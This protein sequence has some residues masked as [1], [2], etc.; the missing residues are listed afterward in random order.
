MSH[1]NEKL[2]EEISKY[3]LVDDEDD[4][5]T[6]NSLVINDDNQHDI[7]SLGILSQKFTAYQTQLRSTVPVDKL[8]EVYESE[9]QFLKEW[10][11]TDTELDQKVQKSDYKNLT[12][13]QDICRFVE[14]VFLYKSTYAPF[15]DQILP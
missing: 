12:P 8:L 5:L 11:W 9:N 1:G 14:K 10:E 15:W 6:L 7:P 4:E 13:E 3:F 2:I